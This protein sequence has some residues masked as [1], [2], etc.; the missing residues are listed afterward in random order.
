[1]FRIAGD[2]PT[3][4]KCQWLYLAL[5]IL[6]SPS[7]CSS[8]T[9]P[10]TIP[11]GLVQSRGSSLVVFLRWRFDR[12]SDFKSSTLRSLVRRAPASRG[13]SRAGD[14]CQQQLLSG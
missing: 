8:P 6:M 14:P 5:T 13:I 12:A 1:M 2:T 4:G 11:N 9:A 7:Q 3:V 10:A